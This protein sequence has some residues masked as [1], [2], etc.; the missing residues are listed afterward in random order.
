MSVAR[1]KTR[2]PLQPEA[3]QHRVDDQVALDRGTSAPVRL[4]TG[5]TESLHHGVCPGLF[6]AQDIGSRR[7]CGRLSEELLHRQAPFGDGHSL[8]EQGEQG[9]SSWASS[10][11]SSRAVLATRADSSSRRVDAA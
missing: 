2:G 10:A 8:V 7:D 3:K 9:P 4:G 5:A 6:A 1:A 11:V